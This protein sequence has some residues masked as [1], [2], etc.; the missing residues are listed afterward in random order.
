M[1]GMA[2]W[3]LRDDGALKPGGAAAPLSTRAR[4]GSPRI[5]CP[6]C[7]WVPERASRWLCGPVAWPE[8]YAGGC[9]RAFNTFETEGVCPGCAH[10]WQWTACLA[11]SLWARRSAWFDD[12]DDA[13][14]E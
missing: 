13:D 2:R 12:A 5:R 6:H 9:G 10:A 14:A 4:S 8:F 1:D 7:A 3:T 11:C